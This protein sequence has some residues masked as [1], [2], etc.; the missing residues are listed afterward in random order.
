MSRKDWFPQDISH[1]DSSLPTF[2]MEVCHECGL[3]IRDDAYGVR[4]A[5]AHY[6]FSM[7]NNDWH[8]VMIPKPGR[9]VWTPTL[10]AGC[11]HWSSDPLGDWIRCRM[12]HTAPKYKTGTQRWNATLSLPLPRRTEEQEQEWW[13]SNRARSRALRDAILA[14]RG[15][16]GF[17]TMWEELGQ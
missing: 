17:A 15:P 11:L 2:Q 1:F 4:L 8:P 6:H 9:L 7:A 14:D 12:H 13:N 3:V 10:C 5:K 16:E